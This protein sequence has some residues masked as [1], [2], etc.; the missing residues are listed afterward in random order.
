[1]VCQYKKEIT[2]PLKDILR[3][4]AIVLDLEAEDKFAVIKKLIDHLASE[5]IIDESCR[6]TAI[7]EAIA[8]EKLMPTGLENGVA[9]PHAISDGIECHGA[10]FGRLKNPVDFGAQDGIDCDLIFLILIHPEPQVPYVQILS[11]I[12]RVFRE[13]DN[14][15]KAR[16]AVTPD[17]IYSLFT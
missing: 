7:K 12:V 4:E 1:M 6:D 5:G 9:V 10:V 16:K 13:E 14:R 17:E 2:M 15:E 3:K 11:Q 8:R